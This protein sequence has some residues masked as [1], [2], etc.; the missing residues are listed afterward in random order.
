M[1]K[2][3]GPGNRPLTAPGTMSAPFHPT[4]VAVREGLALSATTHGQ[5]V[6]PAVLLISGAEEPSARWPSALIDRLCQHVGAVVTYDQRDVGGSGSVAE[7]YAL[8]DLV[9]DALAVLDH[10]DS[11]AVHV[12][13]RGMGG[14]ISQLLA[15]RHPTRVRSL[16]LLSTTAG[17]NEASEQ[18]APWLVDRM[19]ERLFGD[20]PST[21]IERVQAIVE[22]QQ[23]FRGNRFDFDLDRELDAAAREVA[24]SSWPP[25]HVP[26]HGRAVVDAEPRHAQLSELTTPTL[27]VHGTD[28][29]VYPP[30]HAFV[31]HELIP[32]SDVELVE[33]LGHELPVGFV[34]QFVGLLE[35]FIKKTESRPSA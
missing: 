1:G 6:E 32:N 15:L 7:T 9:D 3:I 13:G 17:V 21:P 34:D 30:S 18:P 16:T 29:P 10:V 35:T 23:W 22:Q 14:M 33:G 20:P 2:P 12:V 19:A 8:D 24:A 28:D 25:D 4:S 27:I 31:L 26:G 5:S 11:T